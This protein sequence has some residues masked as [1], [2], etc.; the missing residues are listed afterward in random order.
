MDNTRRT[1]IKLG[2]GV[3][4]GTLLSAPARATMP[5]DIAIPAQP[6]ASGEVLRLV[7]FCPAGGAAPRIGAVTSERMVVDIGAAAQTMG[8][9]LSFDPASML[10]LTAAGPE[11]L[12]QA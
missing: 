3:A 11:G 4:V 9:R 2:T 12:A 6:G 7:T 1:F 5:A 8:K 10:S